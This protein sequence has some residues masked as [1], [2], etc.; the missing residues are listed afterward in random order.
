GIL[1]SL[2]I[3]LSLHQKGARIGP[4]L[5]FL[6]ATSATSITA[7]LVSYGLLGLKFTLFIFFSVILTRLIMGIVG[8]AIKNDNSNFYFPGHEYW[9]RYGVTHSRAGY[10]LGDSF[11]PKKIFWR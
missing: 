8:N 1:G 11:S 5:A 4:V 6:V 9:N 10:Q 2:P 3:A 7:F